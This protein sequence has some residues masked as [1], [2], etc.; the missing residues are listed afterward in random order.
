[1]RFIGFSTGALALGNWEEALCML[2]SSS[3]TAIE[4]STL[5]EHEFL[6]VYDSLLKIDFSKYE[7]VSFH[8]PSELKKLTEEKL[9]EM[10]KPL[11]SKSWP[12]VVHPGIIN[13]HSLWKDF[14]EYLHIENMDDRKSRGRTAE[15]LAVIFKE[16]PSASLCFDI[17]HARHV[18]RTMSEALAI[19]LD[20]W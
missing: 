12:V 9:V 1:M 10:L 18:D 17:G 7:F 4:F 13:N 16:L 6:A 8:A 2:E 19:I 5:R 11:L 20:N 15:E 14:G 3:A